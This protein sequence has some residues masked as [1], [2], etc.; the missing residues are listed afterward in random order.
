MTKAQKVRV[1]GLVTSLV[2]MATVLAVDP[3]E[4]VN[5]Q[6]VMTIYLAYINHFRINSIMSVVYS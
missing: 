4:N 6:C 3:G 2:S 1:I 5:D